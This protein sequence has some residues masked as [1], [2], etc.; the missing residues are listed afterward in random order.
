[1]VSD[2]GMYGVDKYENIS[3]MNKGISEVKMMKNERVK[4]RILKKCY[5]EV[6][7][8]LIKNKKLIYK[9]YDK[10][11]ECNVLF[12]EDINEIVKY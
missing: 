6:K 5:H 1:M 11:I 3:R 4:E 8:L 7:K 9:L 10:L 12:E 2:Y